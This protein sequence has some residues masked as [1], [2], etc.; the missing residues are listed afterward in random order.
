MTTLAFD[1]LQVRPERYAATPTLAFR[2]QITES[3]GAHIYTI[4]LRCQIRIEP[5]QR[6]YSTKEIERLLELFGEPSRWGGT[7]KPI[8]LTNVSIMLKGFRGATETDLLVP[9]PQD[10][11]L[12]AP[13]Y[14]EALGDGDIPLLLLFSGTVFVKGQRGVS[15]VPVSWDSEARCRLPV[16]VWRETMDLYFPGSAW[17]RVRRDTLDT[18]QRY[19]ARQALPSWD[20]ALTALLNEAD[21]PITGEAAR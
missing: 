1:C 2:L 7:L 10:L 17:L 16:H 20:D 3:T 4:A 13:K 9:C 6:H 11:E 21:E 5:H 14:F 8:Q 19:K 18:L 15:V 12:A